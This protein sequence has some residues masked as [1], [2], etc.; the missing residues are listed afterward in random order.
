MS[1]AQITVNEI[2]RT[3]KLLATERHVNSRM[4]KLL[5]T[6]TYEK[7]RMN[8]NSMNKMKAFGFQRQVSYPDQM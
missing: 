8:S 1:Y 4:N 7:T 5:V 2:S 6:E 3:S